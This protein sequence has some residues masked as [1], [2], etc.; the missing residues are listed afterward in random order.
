MSSES[1]KTYDFPPNFVWAVATSAYQIEGAASE[2]GRGPSIW[3]MFSKAGKSKNHTGCVACDSYHNWK[4]DIEM[5][6]ELGV[7]QYRFSISWPRILP[8]GTLKTINQKGV[9]YYKNLIAGLIEAGIEPNVTLFHWDLPQSLQ[10]KGG[11]INPKIVNYYAEYCRFCFQTFGD[12]VKLWATFNEPIV[13]TLLGH[14]GYPFHH[15]P[16]GF[17]EH[18]DW[19]FYLTNHH[20]LLAHAKAVNIYRNEFQAVQKGK[21]G[22]VLVIGDFYPATKSAEDVEAADNMREFFLGLYAHPILK[23]DYPDLVKSRVWNVCQKQGRVTSR[24]PKFTPEEIQALKGSADFIGV[25]YY[26]SFRIRA[27]TPEES[28]VFKGDAR[29]IDIGGHFEEWMSSHPEGCRTAL[30]RF[31]QDYGD[32]PVMI[33]ENG[34]KDSLNQKSELEDDERIDYIQDHLIAVHEAITED[35]VN[36]IGYTYWALMDNF[37]CGF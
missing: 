23:G 32:I 15:A 2:D 26:F 14:S 3:D 21:I 13:F 34:V 1:V 10:D 28:D 5:I 18:S 36:V 30:A 8:D 17:M 22:I 25:N 27:L 31:K 12:Q 37:E 11:F 20:I 33:T 24:L 19:I 4:R 29:K 7:Q 35:K 9:E 16:G 6:K